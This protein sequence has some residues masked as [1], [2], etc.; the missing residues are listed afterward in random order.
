MS[1]AGPP[2]PVIL[3]RISTAVRWRFALDREAFSRRVAEV[4]AAHAP[5]ADPDQHLHS[6]ALDAL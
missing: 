5:T 6:L 2:A 4:V 1:P 3:C